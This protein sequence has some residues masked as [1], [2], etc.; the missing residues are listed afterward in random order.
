MDVILGWP[1]HSFTH[2]SRT[3]SI[4]RRAVR[5]CLNTWRRIALIAASAIAKPTNQSPRR[6]IFIHAHFPPRDYSTPG[7]QPRGTLRACCFV[8]AHFCISRKQKSK[9]CTPLH[10]RVI[11]GGPDPPSGLSI[12]YGQFSA[13]AFIYAASSVRAYVRTR[14]CIASSVNALRARGARIAGYCI[15]I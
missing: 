9:N 12:N 10:A 7:F 8:R 15:N 2:L 14:T 13:L 1:G 6:A 5:H 4:F 11:Y 3:A